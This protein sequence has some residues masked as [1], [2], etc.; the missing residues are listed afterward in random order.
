MSTESVTRG[1][2]A[3]SG[4]GAAR[5]ALR[6]VPLQPRRSAA[7]AAG[8]ALSAQL[9]REPHAPCE[10][11]CGAAGAARPAG[12]CGT[13]TAVAS[14]ARAPTARIRAASPAGKAP[15]NGAAAAG[16]LP[17][18]ERSVASREWHARGR[19]L[20]HRASQ[21][22]DRLRCTSLPRASAR[23]VAMAALAE[24]N[25][26]LPSLVR[27]RAAAHRFCPALLRCGVAYS[28]AD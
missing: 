10:A 7:A 11:A 9:N 2:A 27:F 19:M 3:A 20:I 16:S 21:L 17:A 6:R 22:R 25:G 23:F 28:H 1:A 26:N 8:V 5:R 24:L 14:A 15:A 18:G 13:A 4:D 12:L